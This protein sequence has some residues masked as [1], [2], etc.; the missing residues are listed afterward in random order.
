ME[1]KKE[2]INKILYRSSHRGT[3]EMDILL[4]NFV[5]KYIDEFNDQELNELSKLLNCEDSILYNWYFNN[6]NHELI[7]VNKITRLLKSFKL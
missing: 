3:K 6:L 2:K 7:P 5:K 4:G 1:N